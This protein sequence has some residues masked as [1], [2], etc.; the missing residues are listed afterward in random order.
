[1]LLKNIYNDRGYSGQHVLTP[2]EI[3]SEGDNQSL[4]NISLTVI[5]NFLAV[6]NILLKVNRQV[7]LTR[8]SS[9]VKQPQRQHFLWVLDMQHCSFVYVDAFGSQTDTQ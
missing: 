5:Q 8:N 6:K 4:P 2:R 1:M 9:T 7:P 3:I